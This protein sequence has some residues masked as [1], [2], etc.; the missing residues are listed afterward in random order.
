[1]LAD[2]SLLFASLPDAVEKIV[3]TLKAPH[4][5]RRLSQEVALRGQR[6]SNEAFCQQLEGLVH[7]L[8]RHGG[9]EGIGRQLR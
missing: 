6:F 3:R 4:T 9:T 5:W 7:H 1:M 8:L 2:T